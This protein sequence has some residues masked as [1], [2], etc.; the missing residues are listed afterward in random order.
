MKL[1]NAWQDSADH[2]SPVRTKTKTANQPNMDVYVIW[3]TTITRACR[4]GMP[5][6]VIS[7]AVVQVRYPEE[8]GGEEHGPG[9]GHPAAQEQGQHGRPEHRLLR[10]RAHDE[11]ADGLQG[12]VR[13]AGVGQHRP[14]QDP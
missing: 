3:K 2:S 11:V 5:A 10:H 12:V 8:A 7:Q 14:S 13:H 6:L 4:R 1:Q 9:D